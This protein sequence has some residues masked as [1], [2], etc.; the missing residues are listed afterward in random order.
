MLGLNDS[1]YGVSHEC[2][3]PGD[4][5]NKPKVVK[6]KIDPSSH[7]SQEIDRLVTELM[8]QGERIYE[9]D[10][11]VLK[12]AN[13]D[14][15]ITQEL[16]EVCAVSFEDVQEAVF[17]LNKPPQIISLD[18]SSLTDVINDI[19][20]VGQFTGTTDRAKE[21]T[22]SLR[23]KVD[24]ISSRASQAP[25]KPKVASIEWL[26]PLIIAGHWIPEMV[27]LA[28]GVDGLAEPGTPS[29]RIDVDELLEYDP[30]V[31]VLMPCG[32]DVPRAIQEVGLLENL[33]RWQSISAVRNGRV[34]VADAGSIFSRSGPRLVDGV[35]LLA[36]MIHPDIFSD[37]LPEHLAKR[38]E[39]MPAGR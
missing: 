18:P 33:E 1:L 29:R 39:A 36:Q 19:E 11:D 23:D 37:P 9:V 13:P 32:M 4:A 3:F 15:V 30:D 31:L 16:C 12:Q 24:A 21:I 26:D 10:V 35:E 28:G 6:S 14:L 2:D 20:R 27:Q 8:K 5:R 25:H 22:R 7:T 34:Y 17:H 38:L